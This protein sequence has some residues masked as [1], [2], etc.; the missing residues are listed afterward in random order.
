[1]S[2]TTPITTWA[3]DL[4][5]VTFIYP[6]VGWEVTM[7]VIGVALWLAWTVW[8]VRFENA[9][10]KEDIEKHATSENLRKATSGEL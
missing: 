7:T 1:M 3:V 10:Y 9:T 4:A 8:Q 5:D 2:S 6:F